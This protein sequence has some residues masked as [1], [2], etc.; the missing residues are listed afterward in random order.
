MRQT[1]SSCNKVDVK[2]ARPGLMHALS[3]SL[4]LVEMSIPLASENHA[5][6]SMSG[7]LGPNQASSHPA[8]ASAS[9]SLQQITVTLLSGI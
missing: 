8:S 6:S 9:S 3:F 1:F 7:V 4:K 5:W 2:T